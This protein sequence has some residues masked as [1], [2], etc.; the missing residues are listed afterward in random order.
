MLMMAKNK[1]KNNHN[2]DNAISNTYDKH[3]KKHNSGKMGSN[4]KQ[5]EKPSLNKDKYVQF[6]LKNKMDIDH[7]NKYEKELFD[8]YD[9]VF[10]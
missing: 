5:Q 9:R 3:D 2:I 8:K 1:Y 10:P 6:Q 7:I 4:P